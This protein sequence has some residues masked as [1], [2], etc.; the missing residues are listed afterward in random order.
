[1]SEFLLSGLLVCAKCEKHFVGTTATGNGGVY[2]YYRIM[3][4]TVKR[5]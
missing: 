5:V 3:C 1:M 4:A 2:R